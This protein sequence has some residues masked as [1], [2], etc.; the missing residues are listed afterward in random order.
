[1][2][3][4][5]SLVFITVFS[6]GAILG[7]GTGATFTGRLDPELAI[8]TV[9]SYQRLLSA[10]DMSKLRFETA[11][12]KGAVV[13]AGEMIDEWSATHKTHVL[14]V[15]PVGATPYGWIDID[16]DGL[17]ETSEKFALGLAS[18]ETNVFAASLRLPIKN[19]FFKTFPVA[20]LYFRGVRGDKIKPTDRLIMQSVYALAMG[21]VTIGGKTRLFQYPFEPSEPAISTIEGLFGVDVDG[22][23]QIRNEQFSV[24]SAYADKEEIVFPLGDMFVSTSKIDMATG[25]IVVRKREKAEYQRIDL[26]IGQVMPD[27]TF[28]DVNGKERHLSE[29]RGKYLMVDFWGVWCHDCTRE[30]PFH[31]AAY[32]RFKGRGFEILGLDTDEKIETLKAYLAKNNITWSQATNDSITRL[33]KISYRIQEYPSTLL[34]GPDGKVL[35]L[36]QHQLQGEELL[37]TLD[38]ILPK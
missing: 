29:F 4:L 24:E 21:R 35:V 27:F 25:Q 18:G 20:F 33:T 10:A 3:W 14:L 28:T 1:M 9:H 11:P 7:Q 36:D 8:D 12:E 16:E 13:S 2:Q 6:A 5:R 17:Y 34:L 19:A 32:E 31:L 22:D 38:R 37:K 23:G 26:A 15:E 30:T